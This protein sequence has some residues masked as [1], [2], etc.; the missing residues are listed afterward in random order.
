MRASIASIFAVLLTVFLSTGGAHANM[1]DDINQALSVIER[2]QEIPET[3]VPEV[4][5]REARGLAILTVTKAG[6]IFSGR[7][8]TGIVVARTDK[9][10]SGPSAIGKGG[11]GFGFQA[12]AQ[13][14]E[15][16]IV[17]N[18]PDAVAAFAKGGN[19]S[20]GGSMSFAAGPVGRD[21]EGSMTLGAVMY[22]YSRSQGL[23]AGVSLEGTV[24]G[25]R[26]ETNT[27]FYGKV[28]TPREIL[29]GSI[30]PPAGAQKLLKFLSKY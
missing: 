27:E 10:W 28:V 8:G 23:F 14:S 25:S 29:S 26:D 18:T 4:I 1:Q 7:G 21:A 20:L 2:F 24:I 16:V 11:M 19:L 9:G 15:L 12:G 17:L 30:P 5:M 22:T 6:F 13:V 3:G